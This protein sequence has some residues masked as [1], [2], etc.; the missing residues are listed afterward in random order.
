MKLSKLRE[1]LLI[2]L[3]ELTKPIYVKFFKKNKKAWQQNIQTL[4]RFPPNTLG[5]ALGKFLKKNDFKL[6][7]KLESHDVLHVL[8]GYKTTIEGEIE[9]QF[10]LLGNRKKSFYALFT[11]IIGVC[12]VPERTRAFF[13]EFKKGRDCKNISNWDFEHL[14]CEPLDSLQQQIFGN[15]LK[16]QSFII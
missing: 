13:K 4:S 14:L 16:N 8:L 3:V 12:L 5:N 15:P 1:N 2:A 10:F 6:L 9:M 7:P 11:A